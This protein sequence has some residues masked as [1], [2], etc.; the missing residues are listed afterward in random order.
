MEKE[1]KKRTSKQNRALHLWCRLLSDELNTLGLDMRV[2]L[3]PTWQIWWTETSVKEN[4]WKPIQKAMF[5]KKS[6][7][8]LST[9]EINKIHEQIMKAIGE[10]HGINIPWPS[11]EETKEYLKSLENENR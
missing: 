6:T 1:V 9:V 5:S 2:I 10:K 8:E 11:I 7:T 4:L 3:K